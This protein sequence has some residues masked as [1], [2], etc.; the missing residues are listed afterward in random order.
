M[1]LLGYVFCELQVGNQYIRKARI[2]IAK[3]GT[4]S[5]IGREWLST[6]RYRFTP[7]NEGELDVNSVEKDEE[8]SAEAKQLSNEFPDLFKRN[9]R[10]KKHQV[11][12]NLKSDAKISQQKGRRIPIQLQNAVD[13][14]IKRLLEDGHI[15]K[16]NE[17][18]DDDFI[19]PTVI[20]VK[21]DH[22]VKIALD[23]R[24]LNQA[25]DKDKY[26]MPNLDNLLGMVAEKLDNENGE[27]WYSSVDKTYAYGQVPLHPLTAKHCNFQIIGGESTGT[28]RFV[29]GFYG[30]TVMSREFQKVMD[31][32]LAKFR[33]VLVFIDEILI[34][35]KG[36]KSEH[37]D[38][39]REILNAMN[40]AK[41]QLKAGKCKFGKQ[42]IGWL[43]FKLTSSGISPIN[44]KVQGI[45]GELRPTNL[46]ELRSFLG[47]AINLTDLFQT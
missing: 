47:A 24:A 3:K 5:I 43:G 2:L 36:T 28:Y 41:L 45:S 19:Q 11:K 16:I 27:A 18:K 9:R 4:K 7:K 46:K 30:L 15:E 17:I 34:E 31:L 6:L 22:S 13:A 33:E 32:L 12:I 40:E 38:K 1:N 26:Q 37:L 29:T 35:T 25:I 44:T 20:T 21:K 23:A 14:E 10:I 39:V 8:L 42:E